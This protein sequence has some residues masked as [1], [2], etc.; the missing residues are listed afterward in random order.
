MILF[1]VTLG[2]DVIN[3]AMSNSKVT[4]TETLIT[5]LNNNYETYSNVKQ[6]SIPIQIEESILFSFIIKQYQLKNNDWIITSSKSLS[7]DTDNLCLIPLTELPQYFEISASLRR[8]KSGTSSLAKSMQNRAEEIISELFKN[9]KIT[10]EG[11][12]TFFYGDIGNHPKELPENLYLSPK[13]ENIYEI[14]KRS[15][16]NNANIMFSLKLKKNY[17]FKSKD[18]LKFLQNKVN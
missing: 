16:T 11:K 7:L 1:T 13:E 9:Y 18:F 6:S 2:E 3:L 12:K 17:V 10:I 8:K 14:R 5:H 15:S 4:S